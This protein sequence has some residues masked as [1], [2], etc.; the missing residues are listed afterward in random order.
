MNISFSSSWLYQGSTHSLVRDWLEPQTRWSNSKTDSHLEKAFFSRSPVFYFFQLPIFLL[1]FIPLLVIVTTFELNKSLQNII[2]HI[3]TNTMIKKGIFSVMSS[4]TTL[5]QV[6]KAPPEA[7]VVIL[8]CTYVVELEKTLKCFRMESEKLISNYTP[9]PRSK[10]ND[11]ENDFN[12]GNNVISASAE[13]RKGFLRKVYGILTVQLL[14][15]CGV[16]GT[17][18][19]TKR[20]SNSEF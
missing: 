11:L 13:V 3:S 8:N 17:A 18:F 20:P 16:S 7:A 2:C 19:I 15:T 10:E 4:L 14:M 1:R 12:Y 5:V 9:N 6:W